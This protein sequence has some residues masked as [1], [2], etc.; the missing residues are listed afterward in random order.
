MDL[1]TFGLML[2][3]AFLLAICCVAI[4]WYLCML[5]P[6]FV[7]GAPYVPSKTEVVNRMITLAGVQK[8]DRVADLGCGDGRL[9]LAALKA[10]AATA[11]GYEIQPWL[12][13]LARWHVRQANRTHQAT[14]SNI[15]FWRADLHDVTL[16]FLYQLPHTMKRLQSHLQSNLQPGTRIVSNAFLFPDWE[17]DAVDGNVRLYRIKNRVQ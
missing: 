3:A 4:Y 5:L 11:T 8:E 6:A 10:G 17:P 12:V 2:G 1:I 7:Y 13:R 9:L 15:S 16:L 14:I